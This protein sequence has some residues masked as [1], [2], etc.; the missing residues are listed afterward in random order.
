MRKV[1]SMG[2]AAVL[3]AMALGGCATSNQK[4]ESPAGTEA[5]SSQAEGETKEEKAESTEAGGE[6]AAETESGEAAAQEEYAVKPRQITD[7]KI[8]LGLIP[9][10]MN[11]AYTMTINGAKKHIAETGD[12]IELIVQAPSSNAS[13]ITE[14]GNILETMIQQKVDAIALA[15]ESD[16][17]M[18]PYLREA[19]EADIPVFLFNMTE[20]N[21]KNIYYVS[22]IGYDQEQAGREIG[23]WI[24]ENLGADPQK[25]AV[26]EGYAGVVNTKRMDGFN[27]ALAGNEN[28]PVVASQT[29]EWT[30]EKGQSVTESILTSNPDITILYGPYDEMV[31]GGL[32]VI[33]ERN[34]LDQIAVV[35]FGCTKDGVAAIEA[36]E[37]QATID[38]GEYGTGFDIVDAVTDFCIKGKEVEKVI[39]RPSKVYDKTNL[40]ELDRVIFD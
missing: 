7:R 18:L 40:S 26:L 35:G 29:A 12:N 21:E 32:T 17:S 6:A 15:T 5:V 34:L 11:T 20:I 16:E 36:G 33:K 28:L 14:Q 13:T 2:M 37:M 25:I 1:V 3:L 38:V 22:S 9:V 39:N 8:K 24:N 19:A 27:E 23:A 31:L 4:A 30:R 10:T